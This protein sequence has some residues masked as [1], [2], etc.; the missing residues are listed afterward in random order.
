M[1]IIN[2]NFSKM[3]VENLISKSSNFTFLHACLL[4]VIQL[5]IFNS[6]M[7]YVVQDLSHLLGNKREGPRE[8]VH[9]VW[10]MV[11]ML[12]EVELQDVQGVVFELQ[13]GA[14]VVVDVTIVRRGEDGD[15]FSAVL[16]LVPGVL[17]LVRA[18]NKG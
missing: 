8:K 7:Q 4:K 14:L 16:D 18:N 15:E 6:S 11:R 10:K 2:F 12:C 17:H 13:N 9:E 5:R 1:R 3:F